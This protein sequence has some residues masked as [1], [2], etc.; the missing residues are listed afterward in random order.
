M[1][2]YILAILKS[3]LSFSENHPIIFTNIDFWI[4]FVIVYAVF[5]VI[6]K[7]YNIKNLFLFLVS[8]FFYYK[9]SGL[10]FGLLLFTI[11]NEFLIARVIHRSK[12][13]L[14]RKLLL[15]YSVIINL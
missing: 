13:E 7:Q 14:L 15:A 4:F 6:Y 8:I 12:K 5:T 3:F 10:F 2:E 9:T 11:T 1:I